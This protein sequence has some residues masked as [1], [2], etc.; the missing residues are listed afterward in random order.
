M[1]FLQQLR[2][3]CS[4]LLL[5][6]LSLVRTKAEKVIGCNLPSLPDLCTSRTLRWARKIVSDPSHTGHGPQEAEVCSLI[7]VFKL[8]VQTWLDPEFES[9]R[10]ISRVSFPVNLSSPF[11]LLTALYYPMKT[12]GM[13]GKHSLSTIFR[14]SCS[15]CSWDKVWENI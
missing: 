3:K 10:T 2:K 1:Y 9:A 11:C 7:L 8:S 15:V 6:L 13:F 5:L 14:N 4:T 12:K